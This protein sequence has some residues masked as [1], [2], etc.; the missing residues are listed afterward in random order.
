[1]DKT[2]L[3]AQGM[4]KNLE[5]GDFDTAIKTRTKMKKLEDVLL[6][7][8][9]KIFLPHKLKLSL[10]EV[11]EALSE[12]GPDKK[13][14][15][16]ASSQDK[17]QTLAERIK[18]K[19][20]DQDEAVG[21]VVRALIRSKLGLRSK[22]RPLGNFLFLGPTGV[23]KTELAKVL[24]DSAFGDDS[25]I[26]LDMSDF[27][28]KH[29]V[30]R[31]VGAPPGYIGYGEGGELT[32][33]IELH[34]ESVVLFDEI[35]KAHPDV[36][37]ILLQIMDEGELSDAKGNTFDFSKAVII[38]TS[39][40]GTEI[41]QNTG[42]GFDDKPLSDANVESR[43]KFNLKK[44]LKAELLNRFDEIIVFKRLSPSS[45]LKILNLLITE[46][47]ETLFEQNVAL[48]VDRAAKK[49]L[50]TLGYSQEYGARSLRR[51]L[52]KELLDKI[53][54][55]LLATKKRPLD[56]KISAANDTIIVLH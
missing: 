9:E 10:A 44:I 14:E 40:L 50:L 48:H 29:T 1:M 31:L 6:A 53:A 4:D 54:E 30:S 52:E 46:V 55:M 25:L 42:I 13:L 3:L 36:L 45:Q 35:E 28:E 33:K 51:T 19:I 15:L 49:H 26:R 5:K 7:T 2:F 20:I 39:N 23:G 32:Q 8:E 56:I 27:A 16:T 22:K 24:A 38:L 43:L 12:I 37:N 17:L 34:P 41:L 21:T 11:E 47:V 18:K